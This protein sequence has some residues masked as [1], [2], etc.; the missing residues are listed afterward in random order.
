[1][2]MDFLLD[3]FNYKKTAKTFCHVEFMFK[4]WETKE[5]VWKLLTCRIAAPASNSAH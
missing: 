4:I 1:M 3:E 5:A 2:I